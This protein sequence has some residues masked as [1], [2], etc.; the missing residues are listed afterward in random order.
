MDLNRL[1]AEAL[2]A[3]AAD[4]IQTAGGWQKAERLHVVAAVS[5]GADSMALLDIL[6][7]LN[8]AGRCDLT[9]C[10]VHH[11]LRGEEADRDEA[12]VEA[13]ARG[14]GLHFETVRIDVHACKFPG[15][16]VE[17][18][19]RRLRYD[20]LERLADRWERCVVMTAHHANDQAETVLDRLL[21][22]S[23]PSGLGGMRRS[24]MLGRHILARPLLA[25]Y[26]RDLL[27]YAQERG[28]T[29][30]EDSSN[31][32]FRYKRNRVREDLLPK[33]RRDFNPRIDE[34]LVRLADIAQEEDLYLQTVARDHL[35]AVWVS[36]GTKTAQIQ[37]AG[38]RS[39]PCALQ[40]RV[41]K[42]LLEDIG[43]TLPWRFLDI[44]GI[45]L[46][47][48]GSG[49]GH[50]LLSNDWIAVMQGD[51]L[52]IGQSTPALSAC[53]SHWMPAELGWSSFFSLLSLRWQIMADPV[54]A[55]ER[56]SPSKWEAWFA[57]KDAERFLLRP[58]LEGDRIQPLGMKGT[59]LISDVFIDAKVPKS[60]R[61]RYAVLTAGD[62]I[63]WVPGLCRSGS[64]LV[65]PGQDAVQYIR[66]IADRHDMGR[67]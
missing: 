60:M 7:N 46:M 66:V 49:S 65:S 54:V 53:D 41:I 13:F 4:R 58:W 63:L 59:R 31:R 52:H 35:R 40:R 36:K 24:R 11:G 38:L 17:M 8:E 12:F 10:H 39:L 48:V 44:E 43:A 25:V 32:E 9:V 51:I 67:Q 61:A 57:R 3:L 33:L 14:R 23:G 1:V 18:A 50:R 20:A 29:Y 37:V 21:R 6:A 27:T 30:C 42:L 45:R 34:A 28:I 64:H 16:S 62:E 19:A 22:G 26:K 5:G 56:F 2:A 47:V 55:P 15:E